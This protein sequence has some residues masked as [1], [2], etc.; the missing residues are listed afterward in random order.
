MTT[1]TLRIGT[2]W[3]TSRAHLNKRL[4]RR[5]W[6]HVQAR[7]HT[8]VH[9]ST[10]HSNGIPTTTMTTRRV[11]QQLIE[12]SEG[13]RIHSSLW[14]DSYTQHCLEPQSKPNFKPKIK[15]RSKPLKCL[16]FTSRMISLSLSPPPLP[17][18]PSPKDLHCRILTENH[19]QGGRVCVSS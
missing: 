19:P 11:N 13:D 4:T 5:C 16:H 8:L 18:S 15:T 10:E 6:Q 9:I 2:M 12:T 14:R 1:R 7:Q 3:L 17:L